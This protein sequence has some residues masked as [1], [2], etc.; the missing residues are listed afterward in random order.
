MVLSSHSTY[1]KQSQST[2]VF[3][4]VEV[5]NF[6][7]RHFQP[8]RNSFGIIF[9]NSKQI[10][11]GVFEGG[12]HYQVFQHCKTTLKTRS[13]IVLKT[14]M[15]LNQNG[16]MRITCL[17]HNQSNHYRHSIC[18]V[19]PHNLNKRIHTINTQAEDNHKHVCMM[20]CTI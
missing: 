6:L 20:Q 11:S 13:C 5:I 8:K 19:L 18:T 7:N 9:Q 2:Q 3:H 4:W 17:D 16:R 12:Y 14:L 1:T 10:L 15:H